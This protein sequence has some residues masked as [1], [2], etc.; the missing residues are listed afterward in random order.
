M[1]MLRIV[2]L[3]IPT[4][5]RRRISCMGS[6]EMENISVTIVT[7]VTTLFLFFML[8]RLMCP[9]ADVCKKISENTFWSK[10]NILQS[11]KFNY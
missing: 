10:N 9:P 4:D 8:S 7:N 2:T 5:L 11:Q 6:Q 3:Y 1:E